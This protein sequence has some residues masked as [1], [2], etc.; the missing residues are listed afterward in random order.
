[1]LSRLSIVDSI[2]LW[3]CHDDL[4]LVKL[5]TKYIFRSMNTVISIRIDK[6]AKESAQEVAEN[7]GLKRGTLIGAYLRQVVASRHISLYAPEQMTPK[8]ESLI[9]EVEAELAA[10]KVSKKFDIADDFL[11]D[12]NRRV[13]KVNY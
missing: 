10:G 1:M 5:P 3:V 13:R 9:A 7:T 2:Q 6:Q 8:L 12:L 4:V 11:V